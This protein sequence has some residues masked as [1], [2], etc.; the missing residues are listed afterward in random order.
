MRN[1]TSRLLQI[2]RSAANSRTNRDEGVGFRKTVRPGWRRSWRGTATPVDEKWDACHDQL[3]GDR[4]H[5]PVWQICIEDGCVH[6]I[7]V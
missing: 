2:G 6:L 1:D 3:F 5:V 4:R 7:R